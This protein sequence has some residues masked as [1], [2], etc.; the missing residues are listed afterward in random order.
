MAAGAQRA[1]KDSLIKATAGD[2]RIRAVCAYT[3]ELV[4]SARQRHQTSPTATA[5][6]GKA[7]TGGLLLT[8]TLMKE[9]GRLT[10]RIV[11]DG[12]IGGIIVDAG[13]DGS[14]RGYV[15]QPDL[16]DGPGTSGG[17]VGRE[18]F[19]Y[20]THDSGHGHPYTGVVQLASGELGEDF[21]HYL[22]TSEQIPAAVSLGIFINK[23]GTVASAG[24]LLVQLLP[25]A[26]DE[27]AWRLE[28][29]IRNL[30]SFSELMD[31]C[32]S[33]ADVVA[34]AL[35]GFKIDIMAHEEIGFCCRCSQEKVMAAIASLGE[36]EIR[37][38]LTE[39]G[40]AEVRCHFCSEQYH[41]TGDQLLQLL[42]A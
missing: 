19:L 21:T 36:R 1:R 10:I 9:E 41:I 37:S 14:V 23:D 5:A 40:K 31:Q 27:I 7:L 26:G 39:D 35:E 38:M 25:D 16:D 8:T 2:G 33:P 6:L 30:P 29:T 17:A 34:K 32:A 4:E 24:G 13:A 42:D 12:P 28:Q 3:S 11:G 18:G 22:A 15:G 20:V